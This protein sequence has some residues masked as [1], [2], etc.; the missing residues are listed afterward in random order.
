[1]SNNVYSFQRKFQHK[2]LSVSDILEMRRW[3]T[4]CETLI[5]VV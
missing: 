4:H 5:I 2:L 1:M 3:N